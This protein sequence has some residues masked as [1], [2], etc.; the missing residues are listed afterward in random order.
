MKICRVEKKREVIDVDYEVCE[1]NYCCEKMKQWLR[2][3]TRTRNH[4]R[5]SPNTGRFEI[6]VREHSG[7]HYS[8]DGDSD[9]AVYEDLNYCPFCGKK[10]Q[11]PIIKAAKKYR[12]LFK[13]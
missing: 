13:R 2:I 5:Y 8:D 11:E 12:K 7:S 4:L 6:E 9:K 3:G 10:L 1:N